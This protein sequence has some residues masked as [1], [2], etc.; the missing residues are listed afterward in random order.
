MSLCKLEFFDHNFNYMHHAMAE[1]EE[2]DDDYLA[3]ENSDILID[4]TDLVKANY[5]VWITGDFKFLGIVAEV[6]V[7]EDQTKVTVSP[8]I[9]LFDADVLITT[10]WQASSS[11][12]SGWGKYALEETIAQS[13]YEY[14]QNSLDDDWN[15][16][17]QLYCGFGENNVAQTS[18]VYPSISSNGPKSPSPSSYKTLCSR[19]INYTMELS[20]DDFGKSRMKVNLLSDILAK[21]LQ[22]YGVVVVPFPNFANKRLDVFVTTQSGYRLTAFEEDNAE[23]HEEALA[24]VQNINTEDLGVT[25]EN[26]TLDSA[27]ADANTLIIYSTANTTDKVVYYLCNDG[28]TPA[29]CTA[30]AYIQSQGSRKR[31]LPPKH[32]IEFAS[33]ITTAAEK[34]AKEYFKDLVWNS[35]AEIKVTKKDTIIRPE[36]LELG[37][38]CRLWKNGEAHLAFLTGRTL[39]D[40]I[41]LTFGSVRTT[42]TKQMKLKKKNKS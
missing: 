14:W 26:F 8:F 25:V 15:I 10:N 13:I 36:N 31:I 4:K 6:G 32:A 28:Q 18:S 2:L 5:F 3:P 35:S 34:K 1:I 41:T 9:S 20:P 23:N 16:N 11:S 24:T 39:G 21:A 29:Y 12:D 37:Q 38:I 27:S 17:M 7:E 22:Y 19:T 30:A 33:N 40:E 42:L